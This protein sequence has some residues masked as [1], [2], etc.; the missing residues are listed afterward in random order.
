MIVAVP[1]QPIKPPTTPMPI[2]ILIIGQKI[3]N[4]APKRP[5]PTPTPDNPKPLFSAL[6]DFSLRINS[7]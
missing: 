4:K 2:P 7:S 5:I 3:D 1:A 6:S